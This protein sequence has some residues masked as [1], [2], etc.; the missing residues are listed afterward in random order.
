MLAQPA[1]CTTAPAPRLVCAP[2]VV[3]VRLEL[4]HFVHGVV[5]VHAHKH[6]VRA[7]HHPLLARHK[8]G[9]ADRQV[10]GLERLD[11]RLSAQGRG[12]GER[13]GRG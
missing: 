7:A 11:Q 10:G 12:E 9:G 4:L 8:S 1:A 3:C 6:V 2:D 13:E 5:V